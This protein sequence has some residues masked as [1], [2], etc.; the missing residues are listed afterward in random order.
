[1]IK[2]TPENG[3]CWF[4]E[5][6]EESNDWLFSCEFDCNLHQ[7]CLELEINNGYTDLSETIFFIKEFD[8]VLV[9]E[10]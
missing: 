2:V 5:T 7:H 3:G 4:C 8:Y 1:M 6:I 9:N 10:T